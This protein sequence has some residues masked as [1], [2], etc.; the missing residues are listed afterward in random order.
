MKKLLTV[1]LTVISGVI[2]GQ[3]DN[4]EKY[5]IADS[6]YMSGNIDSALIKFSELED[7]LD[8]QD[9]LY[10]YSLWYYGNCLAIKEEINRNIENWN[11]SLKYGLEFLKVIDKATGYFDDEYYNQKY[12]MYKNITLAYF[13]LSKHEEAKPYQEKLYRAYHEKQLPEGID[14]YYNFEKFRFDSLNVWAYEWYPELGDKETEGSFSK[15]VYYIY[16]TDMNGNDTDQLFTLQTVKVHKS[17]NNMPDYVLTR[18]E[19]VEGGENSNTIW[20]Y[21][22]NSSVNY[23]KLHEAVVEYLKGNVKVDTESKVE[24]GKGAEIKMKID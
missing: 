8:K 15:H 13:G 24:Y 17:D 2:F 19:Y 9:T 14:G 20:S 5:S 10:V 1:I 16:S 4:L 23:Q 11:E 12:W 21:T 18:R 22:F 6:L 7:T 3:E